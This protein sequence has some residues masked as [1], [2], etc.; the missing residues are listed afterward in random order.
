MTDCECFSFKKEKWDLIFHSKARFIHELISKCFDNDE[1]LKYLAKEHRIKMIEKMNV[2]WFPDN[3][4]VVISKYQ[5]RGSCI[6]VCL[7]GRLKMGDSVFLEQG[8][9]YGSQEI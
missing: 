1:I 4:D 5:E 8:N 7:K 2:R 3:Q 9:I 6:I